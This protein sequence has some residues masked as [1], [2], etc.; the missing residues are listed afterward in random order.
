MRCSC[1]CP[2]LNE[3]L[4]L[5]L[6]AESENEFYKREAKDMINIVQ[7]LILEGKLLFLNY[8][9][10]VNRIIF[11]ILIWKGTFRFIILKLPPF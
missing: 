4:G 7:K 1:F 3:I 2:F 9:L 10:F 8:Y 5:D 11:I 6:K